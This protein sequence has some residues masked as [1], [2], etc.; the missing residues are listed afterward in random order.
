MLTPTGDE[1][2]EADRLFTDLC[3]WKGASIS[4]TKYNELRQILQ[5]HTGIDLPCLR[6]SA[7]RL[8]DMTNLNARLFDCCINSC[9]AYTSGYT[10]LTQ[11][12][13]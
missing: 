1:I 13:Q 2:H 11:N 4:R 10:V 3:A 6:C 9:V 12:V 5:D 8:T 7:S